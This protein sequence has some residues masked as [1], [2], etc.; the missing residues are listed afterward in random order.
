MARTFWENL[1]HKQG[2]WSQCIKS[3]MFPYMQDFIHCHDINRKKG[4]KRK[5]I[6]LHWRLNQ[7]WYLGIWELHKAELKVTIELIEGSKNFRMV[8]KT[9][10]MI[11]KSN[12]IKWTPLW[13]TT[14]IT[15]LWKR[16][17]IAAENNSVKKLKS[18][19]NTTK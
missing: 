12:D 17:L 16:T 4:K 1:Y 15:P 13:K 18:N 8:W 6:Y 7:I 19:K 5:R 2:I 14:L 3:C 11:N 9:F 10:Q